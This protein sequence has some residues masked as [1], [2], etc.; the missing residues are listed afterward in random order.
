[1]TTVGAIL[2]YM[3]DKYP[4]ALA[5]DFDNCGLLVGDPSAVVT[6]CV[7]ALDATAAVA[8]DAAEKGANLLLTHHPVIFSP[9]RRFCA[10]DV[11]FEAARNGIA[12]ISSHTCLDKADGGVNDV[13]A[14]LLSLCDVTVPEEGEGILRVGNLPKAADP[15]AFAKKCKDVLNAGGVRVV[16]GDR[17]VKRIAL[18]SGAG[19]SFVE[20]VLALGCDGY[21]TGEL[22]HH[23]AVLAANAGLTVVDAGHFETETVVLPKLKRELE[24]AF[25]EVEFVLSDENVPLM[26]WL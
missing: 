26:K 15:F 14:S 24:E 13:L 18:C 2:S 25:P 19:G 12:V 22:K 20:T 7:L 16:L 23:E 17:L 5:E 1:M 6:R 10:G 8:A 4:F 3:N 21:L 11:P 9:L